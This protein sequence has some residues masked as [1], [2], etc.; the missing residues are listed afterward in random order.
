MGAMMANIIFRK[1]DDRLY[2][3]IAKQD[4]ELQVIRLEFEQPT[5]WGGRI[6]L[7][8]GKCYVIPCLDAI[9]AF[10]ITLRAKKD[11]L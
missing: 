11:P 7:E 3:Y 6:E 10:P 9:P 8:G 1:Q 5:C 2:C 4:L